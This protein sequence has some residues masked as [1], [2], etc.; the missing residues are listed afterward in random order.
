MAALSRSYFQRLLWLLFCVLLGLGIGIVGLR[1]TGE[2]EWFLALPGV[3]AVGWFIF[4]NPAECL[5]PPGPG[6]KEDS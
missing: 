3:M 2:P 4:A 1:L 6:R 5:L